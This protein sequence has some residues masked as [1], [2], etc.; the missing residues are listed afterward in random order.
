MI[1]TAFIGMGYRGMQLLRLLRHIPAFRLEAFA[2]PGVS[3]VGM[4]DVACYNRGDSDYLN[5]LEEQ[6]PALVFVASPWQ[7]H[8]QH[9]IHCVEHG[10]DV[11]LE[12][13]GGLYLD[14]YKPLIELAERTGRRV[15]PLENTLF[16]R[17]NLSIYNLV[18]AGVL[19][20][21]VYMRGGYRHDLRRMLLDDDG[22]LGNRDKT[23]SIWRSQFYQEDNGDLYPTHGLAPLCLIAGIGRTDRFKYVTSF[24]SGIGRTDRFKY[25]TSF[26][27][28]PAGLMQRIRDL[29]GNSDVKIT[30]GDVVVT[31]LET[32]RGV[33]ISL[34]HDTTLPRPRSLDFEIQGTRGIW[35]GDRRMIYVE[36]TSPD[37]SWEPDDAYI[38]RYEHSY[39]KQWGREALEV[40]THHRGMDYVMLKALEEDLRGGES[41][42]AGIADLAL[43]TSATPWSK[44]SIA[45]RRTLVLN[46]ND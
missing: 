20:E 16:M 35:N 15:Y 23:E 19:G 8:V 43:W 41:Y 28:K 32:E 4:T 18:R 44:M 39:W 17:E 45:G 24:A 22:T 25:V 5:M 30:L 31:Q 21:I 42:P 10:A 37:E 11:A 38:D 27:S 46:E 13:K 1:K 3:D 40:D 33:L 6:M 14:E 29:G 26:A 7:C 34:T 9:A 36:G 2:D 12:I